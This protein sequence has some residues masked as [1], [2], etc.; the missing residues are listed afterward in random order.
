MQEASRLLKNFLLRPENFMSDIERYV[1][2]YLIH[3]RRFL[4]SSTALVGE[5]P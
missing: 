2:S 4:S 1:L 5:D 3:F